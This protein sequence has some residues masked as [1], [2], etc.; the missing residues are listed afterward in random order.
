MIIESITSVN[1]TKS[2]VVC[3]DAGVPALNIFTI[4]NRAL[5]ELDLR[6]GQE[7]S[8]ETE[9]Y[10]LSVL[11]KECLSACGNLLKLQDYTAARLK[12]KLIYAGFPEDVTVRCLEEM[13]AARYLDDFRYAE[14][15]IEAHRADRSLNRIREDLRAR[16]IPEDILV[17]ALEENASS[18]ELG[19]ADPEE[20]QIRAFLEKKHYDPE[21]TGYDGKMK[22][23]ASLYRRGYRAEL[24]RKILGNFE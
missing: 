3:R 21:N 19:D 13:K 4:S 10:I 18:A 8:P 14:Q 24:I 17:K 7:V 16:G 12:Q 5:A 20:A 1:R 11:R 2:R 23:M 22:L 15:F 6:E 9:S